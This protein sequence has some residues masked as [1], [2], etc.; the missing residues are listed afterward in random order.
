[1][2]LQVL[3]VG[4]ALQ[5]PQQFVDDTLQVEFLRGE[6]GEPV[7]EVVTTL[8]AEDADGA[9]TC[10]VA[11]LSAFGKDAVENVKILL[12]LRFTIYFLPFYFFTF[13]IFP[14]DLWADVWF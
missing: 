1:M 10:A 9:C 5:E 7:I 4:V 13:L 14:Q 3:H 2:F 8:S 12:H 6:Q 11:F